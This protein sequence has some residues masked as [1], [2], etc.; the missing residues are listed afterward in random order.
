MTK[1]YRVTG[2]DKRNRCEYRNWFDSIEDAEFWFNKV[3]QRQAVTF[4]MLYDN[5]KEEVVKNSTSLPLK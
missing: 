5:E 1:R 2:L 4:V 3:A